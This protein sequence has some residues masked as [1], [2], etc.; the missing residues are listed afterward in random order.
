MYLCFDNTSPNPPSWIS[1][2]VENVRK[3]ENP[4]LLSYVMIKQLNSK[5][6]Y[7]NIYTLLPNG[8]E[9]AVWRFTRQTRLKV[10]L[11]VSTKLPTGIIRIHC[12]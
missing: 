11:H 1:N 5:V 10:K 2:S 12:E 3:F 9:F 4:V 7:K 6:K 8:V